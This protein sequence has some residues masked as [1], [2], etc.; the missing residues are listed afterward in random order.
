MNMHQ[1]REEMPVVSADGLVVGHV[2]SVD[3][4]GFLMNTGHY[5]GDGDVSSAFGGEVY[6]RKRAADVL[7]ID[8]EA[9]PGV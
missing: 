4:D 3:I 2:Q 7:G 6:L 5:F 1:I 8:A 9:Q